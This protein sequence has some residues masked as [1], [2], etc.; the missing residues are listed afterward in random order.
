M[1]RIKDSV[2]AK[3]G[4]KIL[5]L[6][7]LSLVLT[8]GCVVKF[9]GTSKTP[10]VA[11]VFKSFDKGTTWVQK[12]LFIHSGGTGSITG[13]NVVSLNFDPQDNKAI[14]LASASNGLL[15]SYD[16]GDSWFKAKGIPDGKIE[17]VAIDP[18]NKCVIYTTFAVAIRKS[19][20]CSRSWQEIYVDTRAD[21]TVT[22][23]AIDP[24]DNLIIYAGNSAG[25]ILKS[26]DGGGNWQVSNRFGNPI[27]KIL[28]DPNDSRVIYVATK[29]KG[30]F[31]TITAGADWFDI[32]EGLKQYSGSLEYKN[33]IFDLSQPDSLLLVAKYGLIKTTDGGATWE[34][35]KLIT[36]PA[37]TD[38]FSVAINPQDNQEIYYAT[39]S[40][41]YKTTDG[42]QNWITKRLPSAAVATYLLIDPLDSNIIYLGM[43]NLNKK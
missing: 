22:A 42:G 10:V 1:K 2:S 6:L 21:K 9:G 18:K 27:T 13:L 3:G 35:I 31:K 33:L 34:A 41:F 26:I 29:S 30:I 12:S 32:N 39:A 28:I 43:S 8:S 25:D 37:S 36:P 19:V 16:A 5:V 23:L 11:G 40:T 24:D 38:I 14:Y 15:Y 4:K 7:L 17:S 20:D